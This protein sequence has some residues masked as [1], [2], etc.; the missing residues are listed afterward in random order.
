M[1]TPLGRV[2]GCKDEI[3]FYSPD[4]SSC[5]PLDIPFFSPINSLKIISDI[6]TAIW[7][8]T[9]ISGTKIRHA[10]IIYVYLYTHRNDGTYNLTVH[11]QTMITV[12]STSNLQYI[13][14]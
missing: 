14:M 1:D 2:G 7:L 13:F 6:F 4:L 10:R 8:Y 5:I 3:L 11:T 12:Y 9:F